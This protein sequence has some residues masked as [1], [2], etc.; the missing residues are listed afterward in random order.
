MQN[1]MVT[2]MI[3]QVAEIYGVTPVESK[4]LL[5]ERHEIHYCTDGFA[6][7]MLSTGQSLT[8]T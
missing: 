3:K 2:D 4:C 7:D 8:I 5:H 1:T 6:G